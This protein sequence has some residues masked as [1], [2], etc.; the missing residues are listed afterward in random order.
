MLRLYVTRFLLRLF[1]NLFW[2]AMRSFLEGE[3]WHSGKVVALRPC[4]YGFKSWKQP[5][6]EM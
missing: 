6:A 1:P 5:L 2:E 4:G 3:P